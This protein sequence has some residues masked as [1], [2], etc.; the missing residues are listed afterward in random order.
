MAGYSLKVPKA[1]DLGGAGVLVRAVDLDQGLAP[2]R[3]PF[4][5]YAC[6]APL[7]FVRGYESGGT[8]VRGHFKRQ[9]GH[10]H[11]PGCKFRVEEVRKS[12]VA[13]S[14]GLIGRE[15]Q[16][17][18]LRLPRM[19]ERAATPT[20]SQPIDAPGGISGRI[21]AANGRVMQTALASAQRI[22]RHLED[23]E[24]DSEL[25]S[26]YAVRY[27]GGT[28]EWP[29]FC[30]TGTEECADLFDRLV[31]GDAHFTGRP[32]ALH[33]IAKYVGERGAHWYVEE[34]LSE[35]VYVN[36]Q[37]RP[38]RVALRTKGKHLFDGINVGDR[39]LGLGFWKPYSGPRARCHDLT[40]WVNNS[41][42]LTSWKPEHD[43]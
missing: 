32:Y 29:D 1:F 5:C 22:L 38:L 19:N 33:G 4:Q 24:F 28:F 3:R 40:L 36:G 39:Y 17:L 34:P 18:V 42:Q 14:G 15:Q 26:S 43:A 12:L 13:T 6:S 10:E 11:S 7:V 37:G 23:F 16:R 20:S 8:S 2:I 21:F 35:V 31:G 9:R 25:L 27:A 30:R 41:W